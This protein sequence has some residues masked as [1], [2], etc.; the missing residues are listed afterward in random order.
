MSKSSAS[1]DIL[2]ETA[3]S[4]LETLGLHLRIA[5]ERRGDSLKTMAARMGTSIPTLRRMEA[6]DAKVSIGVYA[7][8]LWIFGKSEALADILKPGDDEYATML[9]VNRASRKRA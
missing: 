5:R 2:P 3:V 6:G 1:L 7:A 9:D 8:A 4:A